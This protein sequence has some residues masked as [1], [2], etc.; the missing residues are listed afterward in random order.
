M[1]RFVYVFDINRWPTQCRDGGH[2]IVDGKGLKVR[3]FE[4]KGK[5]K[6]ASTPNADGCDE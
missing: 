3:Y 2:G 4:M 6:R 5:R 1:A